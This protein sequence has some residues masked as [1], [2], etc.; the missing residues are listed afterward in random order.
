MRRNSIKTYS[1][2]LAFN[3][4]VSLII[5]ITTHKILAPPKWYVYTDWCGRGVLPYVTTKV[6]LYIH[7]SHRKIC[8]FILKWNDKEFF[9]LHFRHLLHLLVLWVWYMTNAIISDYRR[10]ILLVCIVPRVEQSTIFVHFLA[11]WFIAPGHIIDRTL[12]FQ[13]FFSVKIFC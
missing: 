9:A 12:F 6:L 8:L 1:V 7:Q 5:Y 4:G 10:G 2:H 11:T 3:F 13:I